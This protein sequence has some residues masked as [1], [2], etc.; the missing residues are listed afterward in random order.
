MNQQ[1]R[2]RVLNLTPHAVHLHLGDSASPTVVTIPSAGDLRLKSTVVFKQSPPI[3]PLHYVSE[4]GEDAAIPIVWAQE[5]TG[6]D[7]AS[8]GFA[9]LSGLTDNDAIIV[10]MPVAHWLAKTSQCGHILSP[11]TGPQ[12]VVRDDK[13]VI[14]GT[15]ALEVHG[16]RV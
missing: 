7:E 9:Y 8:P 14:K 13:G 4:S 2:P 16:N 6:L 11:G 5:F 12:H 3:H 15:R 10:S 1:V